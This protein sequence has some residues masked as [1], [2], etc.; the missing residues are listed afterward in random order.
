MSVADVARAAKVSWPT[1][2]RHLG[3]KEGLD[4]MLGKEPIPEIS[5][6]SRS[7]LL[8]AAERCAQERGIEGSSLDDVAAEA[9]LTKGAVYW[10]FESKQ[11]L[12]EALAD[13]VFRL[14]A[15][16]PQAWI[17]RLVEDVSWAGAVIELWA[18]ARDPA[19]RARIL[20]HRRAL[21][22]ALARDASP[23]QAHTALAIL[24]GFVVARRFDAAP[25]D[26]ASIRRALAS[27]LGE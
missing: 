10:H 13:E 3:G 15:T 7:R 1:A 14:A 25:P 23:A 21:L 19:V 8:Y 16:D 9:G 24:E 5:P 11:A 27:V 20:E 26:S 4:A 22:A 18:S 2:N 17:T 6:D 12:I